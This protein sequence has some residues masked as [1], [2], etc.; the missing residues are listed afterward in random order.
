LDSRLQSGIAGPP[1]REPRLRLGIYV[2]HSPS[3]AGSVA[4]VLNPRTGHVS[5]QYHMVF[6]DLFT[7]VASMK[8]SEV[9]PNWTELVGKSSERVTD[10]DYNLTKTW[11]FPNVES[12]DIAMQP[13][14]KPSIVPIGINN[15]APNA[16]SNNTTTA[17]R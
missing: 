16:P 5:P 4:L 12:G 8:K 10:E 15:A 14:Q 3:H 11:L 2:G 7:R 1:K 17:R 6:D 9:P 13:N